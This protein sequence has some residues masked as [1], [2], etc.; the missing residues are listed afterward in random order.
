MWTSCLALSQLLH[1]KL[2]AAGDPL[3]TL[4][5]QAEPSVLSRDNAW[6]RL[7][8][9]SRVRVAPIAFNGLT[10]LI[11]GVSSCF[12]GDYFYWWPTG[13]AQGGVQTRLTAFR[14]VLELWSPAERVQAVAG[15]EPWLS[16]EGVYVQK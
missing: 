2:A 14:S 8:C 3:H 13:I 1:L 10:S 5:V 12:G 11:G 15:W 16:I 9:D 7:I 6:L 4:Y